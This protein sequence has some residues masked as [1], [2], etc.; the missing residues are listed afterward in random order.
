MSRL[1]GTPNNHR[2]KY[3]I[4]FSLY[5]KRPHRSCHAFCSESRF[6][7][8]LSVPPTIVGSAV[9]WEATAAEDRVREVVEEMG[10]DQE[11]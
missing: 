3:R 7:R 9:E 5:S 10:W 4:E 11:A 6:Q 8:P 2:M 1:A